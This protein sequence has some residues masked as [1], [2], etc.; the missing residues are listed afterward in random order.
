MKTLHC[1][2]AFLLA[3]LFSFAPTPAA[4]A[5]SP[6]RTAGASVD[7]VHC[8]DGFLI[9]RCHYLDA[10][11]DDATGAGGARYYIVNF[12]LGGVIEDFVDF[13]LSPGQ[14]IIDAKATKATLSLPGFA[15]LAWK[16]NGVSSLQQD[17]K[18]VLF[19]DGVNTRT[20]WGVISNWAAVQGRLF[21]MA[22]DT[23]AV[24]FGG[25]IDRESMKTKAK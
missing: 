13:V 24:P 2:V 10:G 23:S 22:V 7:V 1:L 19:S 20:T 25:T 17:I 9:G 14:L 12:D 5:G 3:L 15:V 6:L 11:I 8:P 21:G 18:Q 16:K 4:D